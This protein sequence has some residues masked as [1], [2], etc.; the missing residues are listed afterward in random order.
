M[1]D[2]LRRSASHL[3]HATSGHLVNGLR[4]ITQFDPSNPRH[5]P[6]SINSVEWGRRVSVDMP[7]YNWDVHYA[8]SGEYTRARDSG[9][10]ERLFPVRELD[11]AN[12]NEQVNTHYGDFIPTRSELLTTFR[13]CFDNAAWDVDSGSWANRRFDPSGSF[14][15]SKSHGMYR[16]GRYNSGA[17]AKLSFGYRV[18]YMAFKTPNVSGAT[19]ITKIEMRGA[20]NDTVARCSSV[21]TKNL[22][23]ACLATDD[24]NPEEPIEPDPGTESDI[25]PTF[26]PQSDRSRFETILPRTFAELE[27]LP[28]ATYG[29]V[30]NFRS[31]DL[32]SPL[33]YK[34]W[35]LCFFIYPMTD[36][37]H[38]GTDSFGDWMYSNH[39]TFT[40]A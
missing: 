21:T 34:K 28:R 8:T 23:I 18:G 33:P 26:T 36:L 1:A 19:T 35:V 29:W 40:L 6:W 20:T 3:Y 10:F 31:P 25:F 30:S 17:W 16:D 4:S 15:Y 12:A 24:P 11:S 2:H 13:Q 5:T 14:S 7:S 32:Q 38:E 39:C 37:L 22:F 9:E 27:A